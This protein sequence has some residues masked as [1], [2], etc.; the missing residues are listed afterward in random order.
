[1][2]APEPLSPD[3]APIVFVATRA[4]GAA[5]PLTTSA[6]AD[7]AEAGPAPNPLRPCTVNDASVPSFRPATEHCAPDV[8]QVC[9]PGAAVTVHVVDALPA[10]AGAVHE[11]TVFPA[12]DVATTPVGVPGAAT[13]TSESERI[14]GR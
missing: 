8:W 14:Q 1:M 5:A 7:G 4:P 13:G 6:G 11:T 12:D 10:S 3:H 2:T 9:P